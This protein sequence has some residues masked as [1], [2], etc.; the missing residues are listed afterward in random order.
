MLILSKTPSFETLP[1][2]IIIEIVTNVEFTPCAFRD[3]HVIHKRLTKVL[4]NYEQSI[5]KSI[6]LMQFPNVL[7]DFPTAKSCSYSWLSKCSRRYDVIEG[8]V[9]I[10]ASYDN[11]YRVSNHNLSLVSAGFP[12]LYRLQDLCKL[13]SRN[14]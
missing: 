9:S 3:L 12:L 4:Q 11:T 5:A 7:V 10:L 2:E 8:I 1:A 14:L 13:A 6:M